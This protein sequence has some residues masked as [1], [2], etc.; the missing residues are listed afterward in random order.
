MRTTLDIPDETYRRV[1]VFAAQHGTT[2][3][4]LVLDGLAIVARPAPKPAKKFVLPAIKS[5]RPG[6]LN[7]TNEQIDEIAFS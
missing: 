2:V 1:K 4:Q 5:S 6:S 3:R 7:L